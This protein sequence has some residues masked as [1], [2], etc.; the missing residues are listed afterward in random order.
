MWI[1][2]AARECNLAHRL[3]DHQGAVDAHQGIAVDY[4]GAI[5]P[6]WGAVTDC[7][8]AAIAHRGVA[9]DC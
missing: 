4:L 5:V 9:V 2:M 1:K 7:Q 3:T 6:R 8:G